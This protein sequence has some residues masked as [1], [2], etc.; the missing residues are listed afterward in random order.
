VNKPPQIELV[1]WID[2][3]GIDDEWFDLNTKHDPRKILSVGYHVGETPDYLYLATT[4]DPDSGT[5]S[6]AI[7]VYKPCIKH[8]E[9]LARPGYYTESPTND[10]SQRPT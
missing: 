9:V 4:F 1:L 2:S 5:Y 10:R 7:A 6:V 8:R 3:F